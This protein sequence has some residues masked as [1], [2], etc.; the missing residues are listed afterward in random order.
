MKQFAI[1][2]AVLAFVSTGALALDITTDPDAT[3][4][5]EQKLGPNVYSRHYG[6]ITVTRKGYG[7]PRGWGYYGGAP[8]YGYTPAYPYYGGPGY[9]YRTW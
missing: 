5:Q 1:A 2:A 8:A 9:G 3:M 4:N 7:G 6:N